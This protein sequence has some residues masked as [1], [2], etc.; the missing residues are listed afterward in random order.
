M[1][2]R[3]V[4]WILSSALGCVVGCGGGASEAPPPASASPSP[5]SA[6]PGTEDN[7]ALDGEP[8]SAASA[9]EAEPTQVQKATGPA[10]LTL[11]ARVNGKSIPANVRLLSAD[12]HEVASGK[13]GEAIEVS[14]G[15]YTMEVQ[16]TDESALLDRPTQ[17]RQL[18]VNPGDSLHEHAD[19]PWAMIQL[20]VRVNGRLDRSAQVTLKRE[21]A[22]V[23]KVTSNAAPAAI[24]PGRYEAT[25]KAH[26]ANID[27]KGML[28]PEGGTEKLPVDVRM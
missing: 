11:D 13:T 21:G 9:A 5:A 1:K 25:V 8:A 18:T 20:N 17:R 15:Q 7:S 6:S 12:D 27:V 3:V 26:G 16:V 28:F 2:L 14:S 24:S 19:F 22:E 10:S 23:A 4:P